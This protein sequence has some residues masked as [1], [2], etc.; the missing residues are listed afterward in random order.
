[1]P[2]NHRFKVRYVLIE[3]FNEKY[4]YRLDDEDNNLFQHLCLQLNENEVQ[5]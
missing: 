5:E 3:V 4:I 1:M 2:G